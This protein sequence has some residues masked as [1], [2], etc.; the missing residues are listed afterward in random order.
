MS[1]H[2]LFFDE[3]SDENSTPQNFDRREIF[4]EYHTI[5]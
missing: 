3:L 2:E 5:M 4:A 1:E